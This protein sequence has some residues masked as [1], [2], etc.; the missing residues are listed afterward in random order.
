MAAAAQAARERIDRE[1]GEILPI[2]A[3][4]AAEQSAPGAFTL[5]EIQR[6]IAEEQAARTAARALPR[7]PMRCREMV[8][9]DCEDP[10]LAE[11]AVYQYARGGTDI[12]GASIRL[13]EAVARRWGNLD[14]GIRE[15]ARRA[16]ASDCEAFAIDLESGFRDRRAFTVRHWRDTKKGG[17]AVTDERDIY[18]IVANAGQRRKRAC[19][20]AVIPSGLVNAAVEACERTMKARADTSPEA[21]GKML[22]A[23]AEFGVTRAQIEQR[24]QR[25]IEAIAPAQVVGLKRIYRSLRDAMSTAADWFEPEDRAAAVA[26]ATPASDAAPAPARRGRRKA[27]AENAAPPPSE[28][29]QAPAPKTLDAYRAAIE[30][31]TDGETAG[32]V[33]DEA[34]TAGV[35]ADALAVLTSAWRVRWNPEGNT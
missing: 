18:E 9:L 14:T 6:A 3:P 28:A 15:V 12:S 24:L 25:R 11:H 10:T 34:R 16:G 20:E 26:D 19:L 7:E 22:D 5:V 8:M 2:A 13:L 29:D 1:T 27:A 35:D 4:R 30:G 32:L 33:L 23:F 17:Y 31:A 21:M